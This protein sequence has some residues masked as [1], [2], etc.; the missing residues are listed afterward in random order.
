M[1]VSIITATYNSA[2]TVGDTLRSVS[3]QTYPHIEH[4]LVDGVSQ[5]ATLDIVRSFPHVAR[6][7]CEPDRGIYDAMNKGIQAATGDVIGILNSD[8]FYCDAG[9]IE[10]IVEQL[11]KSGAA[12]LYGDLQF[13]QAQH[14]E[15]VTRTWKAGNFLP[16][17]FLYGWMPPHPTFFVRHHVYDTLGVFDQQFKSAADYELMLRFLYKHRVSVCYLPEVITKMRTGGQS[18]ANLRN[19]LLANR[20]DR[21]AWSVNGLCPRFYTLFLKPLRKLPQFLRR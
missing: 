11:Q 20:E 17:N 8:D 21:K 18:T 5:D 13:V 10:K 2:A 14:P 3:A 6:I 4:I 1:K 9:I 7:I 16:D 19:R 15:R 12:C